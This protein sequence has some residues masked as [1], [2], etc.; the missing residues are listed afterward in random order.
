[1]GRFVASW[2]EVLIPIQRWGYFHQTTTLKLGETRTRITNVNGVRCCLLCGLICLLCS[3]QIPAE[4][5]P[6][7]FEAFT[8]QIKVSGNQFRRA[9]RCI[10]RCNL[11]IGSFQWSTVVSKYLA[12]VWKFRRHAF[13]SAELSWYMEGWKVSNRG[14]VY[15][16]VSCQL[17]AHNDG[18]VWTLFMSKL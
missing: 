7:K 9:F 1:M 10:I 15:Q 11:K 16:V 13:Q 4:W 5:L 2:K 17:D 14:T 8:L 6:R 12:R 3:M 18:L